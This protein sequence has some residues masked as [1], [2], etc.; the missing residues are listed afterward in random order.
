LFLNAERRYSSLDPKLPNE[1]LAEL[2]IPPVEVVVFFVF[3]FS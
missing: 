1:F 3:A 2:R